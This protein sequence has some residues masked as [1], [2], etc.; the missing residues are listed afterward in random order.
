M[1]EEGGRSG[2]R[3]RSRRKQARIR[4]GKRVLPLGSEKGL[5][6][7]PTEKVP[8]MRRGVSSAVVAVAAV[9][10]SVVVMSVGESVVVAA[11]VVVAVAAAAAVVVLSTGGG[12]LV[13]TLGFL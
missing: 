6:R 7:Q 5:G 2:R 8:P 13:D 9:A 12:G 11:L 1:V 10:V 3:T 4:S